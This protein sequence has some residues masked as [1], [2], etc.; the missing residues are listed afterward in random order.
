MITYD[1]ASVLGETSVL[2]PAYK[3]IKINEKN[4]YYVV[5]TKKKNVTHETRQTSIEKN[6]NCMYK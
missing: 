4:Y 6:S 1:L 2:I 5:E 3:N